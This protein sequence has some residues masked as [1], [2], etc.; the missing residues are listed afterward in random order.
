MTRI[1]L[2]FCLFI[3][4]TQAAN[5]LEISFKQKA[6]VDDSVIRL[7]DIA[8]FD[9]ETEMTRALATFTVSQAPAPGE[10]CV[11]R[12]LTIKEN[13]V[14]GQ[15][16]SREIRWT[17]SPAVTVLR[18][19][20]HIGAERIST[21]IAEFIKKNKTNLPE[22][23]MRFVPSSL[24]LP[25][26]LP[27]GELSYEV[28]PSDPGILGSSRFSIIF[29][30]DRKVVKNMSVRGKIEALAHVVVA[31]TTLQRG[32]ILSAGQLT[33]RV[34][35]ISTMDKVGSSVQEL[36]GKKLRRSLR[37]G[38]PVLASMVEELPLV[39]R[40]E[41]V[42]IVANAG[43]MH[44]TTLGLAYSDGILN[45]MIQVKNISSNKVIYGRVAAP[46]IVE[47]ML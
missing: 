32:Q 38:S 33:T 23:E 25:F 24:P 47:V 11:L 16:L 27:T 19:G 20:I 28:I 8:D 14:A 22:A 13:L 12:S 39:H 1:F 40:G 5:G 10:K 17:G 26:V 35:D 29:R 45:Q 42:K 9:A 44:L 37:A 18:R 2:I 30:V 15:S 34:L 3:G 21:I 6:S 7:G 31:A 41:R 36:V 46:G 4:M 43:P